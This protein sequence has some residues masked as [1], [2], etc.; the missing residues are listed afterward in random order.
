MRESLQKSL[1]FQKSLTA[2]PPGLGFFTEKM[3]DFSQTDRHVRS[4]HRVT[5]TNWQQRKKDREV[6]LF[7]ETLSEKS[8]TTVLLFSMTLSVKGESLVKIMLFSMTFSLKGESIVSKKLCCSQGKEEE[9]KLF[10]YYSP[11]KEKAVFNSSP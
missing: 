5:V 9:M 3:R 6:T 10:Y 11:C 8:Y 4:M 2:P 1:I 7:Y